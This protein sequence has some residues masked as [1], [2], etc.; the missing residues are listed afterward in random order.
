MSAE[1]WRDLLTDEQRRL[2]NAACGDLARCLTWHGNRLSKDDWRHF[3]AGTVLGFRMMPG[4]PLGDAAPGFIML[5]RSSL[6]LPKAKC[7][8]AIQIAFALGD[9]PW[10]YEPTQRK[11]VQWGHAVRMARGITDEEMAA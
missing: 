8:E 3:L 1:P 2:L 11:A 7:T 5:G 9:A 6:D 10:E 4:L